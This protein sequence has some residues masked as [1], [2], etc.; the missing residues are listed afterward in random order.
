MKFIHAVVFQKDDFEGGHYDISDWGD[1][2]DGD[3]VV[4]ALYD[5]ENQEVVMVD[6]NVHSRIE[7]E[8]EAYFKGIERC[9]HEVTETKVFIVLKE[10]YYDEYNC[11]YIEEHIKE[12]LYTE[13]EV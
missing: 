10:G 9:C 7:T 12:G 3:Y 8:I 13:V 5:C 6:D 11:A 2:T 1:L 4:H